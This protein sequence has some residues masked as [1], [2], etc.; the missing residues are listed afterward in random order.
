M[1]VRSTGVSASDLVDSCT[2]PLGLFAPPWQSAPPI[3]IREAIRV[4][5][6]LA[7]DT[8]RAG[9]TYRTGHEW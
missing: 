4:C 8:R 3:R 1:V 5:P 9:V 6:V 7:I 2:R